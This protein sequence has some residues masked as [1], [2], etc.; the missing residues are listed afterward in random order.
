MHIYRCIGK[1]NVYVI[2]D[3]ING[4]DILLLSAHDFGETTPHA[5]QCR[6]NIPTLQSYRLWSLLSARHSHKTSLFFG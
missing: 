4:R 6:I 5:A 2:F 1:S 3:C